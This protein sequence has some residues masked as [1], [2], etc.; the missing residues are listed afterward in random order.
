MN[1]IEAAPLLESE[2]AHYVI[3]SP[4]TGDLSNQ[5]P[6]LNYSLRF[7]SGPYELWVRD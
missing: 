6:E 5:L 1:S 7:E 3:V 4:Y 2:L